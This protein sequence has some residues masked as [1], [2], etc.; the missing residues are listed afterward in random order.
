MSITSE[1]AS[2]EDLEPL[3]KIDEGDS[4]AESVAAFVS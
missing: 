2:V 1:I 3:R 4:K